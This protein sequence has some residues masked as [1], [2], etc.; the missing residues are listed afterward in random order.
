MKKL[1]RLPMLSAESVSLLVIGKDKAAVDDRETAKE[2]R[3]KTEEITPEESAQDESTISEN[4][5]GQPSESK[6]MLP[7]ILG[8]AATVAIAVCAAVIAVIRKRRSK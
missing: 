6:S 2:E 5:Q 8:G 3:F 4:E 7:W 1:K